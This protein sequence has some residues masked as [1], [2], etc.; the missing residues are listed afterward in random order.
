MT[1]LSAP[2]GCISTTEERLRNMLAACIPLQRWMGV[3][4]GAAAKERIY[5]AMMEPPTI[6]D[7]EADRAFYVTELKSRRPFCV[8]W[9]SSFRIDIIASPSC[10][11]PSGSVMVLFEENI[12][13]EL[14]DNYPEAYRRFYSVVGS[15]LH[16]EA[17]HEPGLVELNGTADYLYFRS[18]DPSQ[19][20]RCPTDSIPQQGDSHQ[21]ILTVEWGTTS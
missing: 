3:T 20:V 9:T 7:E 12:A 16:S 21:L 14:R 11:S 15:I 2:L 5:V 8:L 4:D 1:Q 19:P 13:D 17:R 10:P 6:Y 18:L